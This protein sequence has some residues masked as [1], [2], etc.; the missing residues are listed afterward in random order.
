MKMTTRFKLMTAALI[1]SGGMAFAAVT[2]DQVV[3]DLQAEGYSW[4]EVKQ[5][6]NQIKVEA[7]KGTTKVETV[8]SIAL[9]M[10]A[11]NAM[12]R[13]CLID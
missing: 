6:P 13:P 8:I 11:G 9:A 12:S 2:T 10:S 5:G 7:V 4:I 1:L 3:A